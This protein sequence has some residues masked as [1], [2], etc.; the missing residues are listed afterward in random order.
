M[1]FLRWLFVLFILCAAGEWPAA[2]IPAVVS[3]L[4]EPNFNSPFYKAWGTV[5]SYWR[6]I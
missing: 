3:A 6:E 1:K 5:T 4:D 2:A